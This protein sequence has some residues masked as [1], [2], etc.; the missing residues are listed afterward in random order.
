M[1]SFT[2]NISCLL[3][4]T[5]C[6]FSAPA[7]SRDVN[8]SGKAEQLTDQAWS[9]QPM[10]IRENYADP[11]KAETLYKEALNDSP[12][13]A[14]TN[15]LLVALLMRR[16][17]YKEA[18]EHNESFLSYFPEDPIATGDRASLLAKLQK[19]YSRAIEIE[20]RLLTTDVNKNGAV[21]YDI[22]G[23]YSL[24]NKPEDSLKYLQLAISLNPAWANEWNARVDPDFKNVRKDK[25]FWALVNRK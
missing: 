14:R 22:A 25:R 24:L 4:I 3:S 19:D 5:I 10:G 1:I 18:N 9:A 7:Q 17:K 6:A 21:Y 2:R 11:S 12:K 23:F 20:H 8:C 15:H 16:K 13:C